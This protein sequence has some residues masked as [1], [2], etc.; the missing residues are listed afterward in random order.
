MTADLLPGNQGLDLLDMVLHALPL[1]IK[2]LFPCS[3][4]TL[5]FST[6]MLAT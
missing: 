5:N 1:I 3:I 4:H 6:W 2:A